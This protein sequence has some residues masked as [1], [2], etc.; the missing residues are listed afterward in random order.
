MATHS[1]MWW[2]TNQ[3]CS[4]IDSSDDDVSQLAAA[5]ALGIIA[6]GKVYAFLKFFLFK[7]KI[8]LLTDFFWTK[9]T[10]FFLGFAQLSSRV[11]PFRRWRL[12]FRPHVTWWVLST[13]HVLLFGFQSSTLTL[14]LIIIVEI[15]VLV[16]S[17]EH[18]WSAS[19]R[20]FALI[21]SCG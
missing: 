13:L 9:S 1:E 2:L 6:T 16:F 18:S 20:A 4:I 5:Q 19:L 8:S 3:L 14:T 11:A 10:I 21:Y 17:W 15:S 12:P 7:T